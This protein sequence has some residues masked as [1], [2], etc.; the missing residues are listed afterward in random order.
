[1]SI[2]EISDEVNNRTAFGHWEI[3]T[4][5]GKKGIIVGTALTG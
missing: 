4:I 2:E 5:V 3:D 1:M